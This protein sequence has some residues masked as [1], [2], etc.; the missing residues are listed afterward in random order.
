M[1]APLPCDGSI[2]SIFNFNLKLSPHTV[3]TMIN[4]L[5]ISVP[6]FFRISDLMRFFHEVVDQNT[7]TMRRGKLQS[8]SISA[9]CLSTVL[10][11]LQKLSG[12]KL[13]NTKCSLICFI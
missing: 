8:I 6:L 11:F 7:L 2:A 13:I 10:H 4:E 1:H 5:E 12:K 9:F 3:F